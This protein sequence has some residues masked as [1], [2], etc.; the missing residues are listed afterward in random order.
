MSKN[1][2]EIIDN[3]TVFLIHGPSYA[4]LGGNSV[5]LVRAFY[6]ILKMY[7]KEFG[8]SHSKNC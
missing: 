4:L 7:S 5:N 1:I 3:I 6:L 2:Y 8:S